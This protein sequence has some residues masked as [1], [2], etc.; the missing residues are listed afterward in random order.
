MT[1]P[2]DDVL[3]AVAG[4]HL[5]GQPLNPQ[6]LDRGAEL[7][8]R[9]SLA[10]KYRLFALATDPPKPGVVRVVEGGASL[11]VEVWRMSAAAFGDFVAHLPQ[12]MAIGQVELVDGRL[13]RG[14]VVEQIAVDGADDIT[15][16]GGWRA[17]RA[18]GSSA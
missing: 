12:P 9:T 5:S 7:V 13:V 16:F 8:E 18:A 6:L 15:R 2:Y 1:D 10:P 11:E 17:Y 14:F 3:L 4:A